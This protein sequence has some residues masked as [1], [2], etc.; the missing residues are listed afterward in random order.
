[1]M[2]KYVFVGPLDP[3]DG[4]AIL[5]LPDGKTTVTRGQEFSCDP[6]LIEGLHDRFL[7]NEIETVHEPK[8]IF[9]K[10]AESKKG[11]E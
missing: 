5:I 11:G 10:G 1:M 2:K 6:S 8:V 3:F 7:F 9:A 4:T